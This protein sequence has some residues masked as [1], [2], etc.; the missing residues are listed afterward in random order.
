MSAQVRDY[1]GEK[2]GLY[3]GFLHHYT[4]WLAGIAVPSLIVSC[5]Q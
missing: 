1:F 3:F 5:M 4:L 2:I